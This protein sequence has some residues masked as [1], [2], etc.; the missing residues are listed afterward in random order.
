M[1]RTTKKMRRKYTVLLILMIA[2]T[3]PGCNSGSPG[4]DGTAEGTGAPATG[5]SEKFTGVKPYYLNGRLDREVTYVKGVRNGPTKTYYASGG[6]KQIIPFAN[7]LQTDTARWFYEDG[8]LYRNTPYVSDTIHG[9]QVQYYRSGRIKAKMTYIMGNRLPDLE[10]YYD[11]GKMKVFRRE[12]IIKTR[13]EYTERG[14]FKIFAELDNKATPVVFYLGELVDGAFNPGTA[15]KMTNSGGMGFIEL[16]R[17]SLRNS[18]SVL[19]IAEYM[20]DFGNKN[21]LTKRVNIPYR[22][23]N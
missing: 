22:D 14:V 9:T 17:G 5:V 3:F 2:I 4:N 19:V 11:N 21:F 20:T 18:G 7:G 13:D 10:E 6:I 12:L 15:I 1:N 23:V 8:K 16:S